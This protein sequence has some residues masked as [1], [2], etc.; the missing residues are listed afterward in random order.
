M[1]DWVTHKTG[2][3]KRSP[4]NLVNDHWNPGPYLAIVRNHLDPEY[5]GRIAVEFVYKTSVGSLPKNANG[6]V[7]CKYLSPFFGTTTYEGVSDNDG[8]QN[9]QKSYGM[10]FVPP[11]V[12]TKVLVIIGE[13]DM[14]YW[15]GCVIDE[16]VN[17]MLPGNDVA[18]SYNSENTS[19]KLPVGE[20]NQKQ[21][22][23]NQSS[24]DK[25]KFIK[26]VNTDFKKVLENQGLL[27][28]ETRGLTTSS[29][30]REVPSSVFGIS[31]PGPLDKRPDAPSAKYQQVDYYHN[32][33]GG[34]SIVMDDGD[35]SFLRKSPAKDSKP[36]YANLNLE[37]P[38]SGGDP[39]L[40]HNEM[41]R[42]KT[43]TGHQI[44]MHNSEDLIYIG[45][46]QGSTWIELTSNGKI[47]IYAQDSISIHSE[48][49]LNFR[50]DRDINLEAGRNVNTKAAKDFKNENDELE[51]G[52]I[53][54][55]TASDLAIFVGQDN[56][57]TTTGR[58]DVNTGES[59]YFSAVKNTEIKS[60]GDHI[61]YTLPDGDIHMN[62]PEA[63]LAKSANSLREF[64]LPK[65]YRRNTDDFTTIQSI[66]KRIPQ[67]EPWPQ[68]ENLD[69]SKFTSSET[70][71]LKKSGVENAGKNTVTDTFRKGA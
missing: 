48:N 65:E 55:E 59:S 36:E 37:S 6:H 2:T 11:D 33:L 24:T 28:D 40:P 18:T 8:H 31:T 62:G 5:Q 34:S 39:T 51:G 15:I 66:L 54:L 35:S 22:R 71:I 68:H 46:S 58:L 52:N 12:G 47:D 38:E 26:P 49:D 13:G 64:S 27:N 41:L 21:D 43:R 29:A 4:A 10:W 61:E 25:T 9:S 57:I 60:G 50:A 69:P 56:K 63:T 14:P 20:Y 3:Y 1:K 44:L 30:R 17:F 19:E 67:H 42:L 7:I 32:R 53:N 16:S 23:S 45:N 70:D